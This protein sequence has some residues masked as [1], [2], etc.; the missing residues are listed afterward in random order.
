[1]PDLIVLHY[2][3]DEGGIVRQE[4]YGPWETAGGEEHLGHIF[5]F[6]ADWQRVTGCQPA[7]VTMALVMD[8]AAW[9]RDR[10]Q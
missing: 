9:V 4:T 5:S 3:W 7:S 8:P 1:M 6:M 2:Q 10:Q